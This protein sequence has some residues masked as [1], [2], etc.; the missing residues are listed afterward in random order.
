MDLHKKYPDVF[1]GYD[2]SGN[3]AYFNPLIH[4][5]EAL[6]YPS[7]QNPPYKLPYFLHVGETSK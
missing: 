3:E 6:L 5:I 1:A 4:Y 2:M 7:R